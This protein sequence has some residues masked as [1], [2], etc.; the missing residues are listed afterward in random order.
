MAGSNLAYK[1]TVKVGVKL[2]L[3]CN[4]STVDGLMSGTMSILWKKELGQIN[5]SNNDNNNNKPIN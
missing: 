3:V 1:M 5:N 4:L 2:F